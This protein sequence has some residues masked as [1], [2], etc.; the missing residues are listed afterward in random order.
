MY[1]IIIA[2]Q[3]Y[4]LELFPGMEV[5][6]SFHDGRVAGYRASLPEL[7]LGV[8]GVSLAMLICAIAVS[9]LPL[10]PKSAP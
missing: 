9:L 5:T 2:G 3:A 7:L 1:V 4:P 6:S 10:L 8:S